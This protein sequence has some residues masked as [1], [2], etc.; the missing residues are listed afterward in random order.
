MPTWGRAFSAASV[1]FCCASEPDNATDRPLN[2]CLY[3]YWVSNLG[4]TSLV[5]IDSG[6][7]SKHSKQLKHPSAPQSAIPDSPDAG[8]GR[9]KAGVLGIDGGGCRGHRCSALVCAG[10]EPVVLGEPQDG[11]IALWTE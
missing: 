3:V 11:R 5:S 10:R 7:V 1:L 8:C 2:T 6:Q 9:R 4:H